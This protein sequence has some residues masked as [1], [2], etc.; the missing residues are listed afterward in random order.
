VLQHAERFQMA[1]VGVGFCPRIASC[2]GR[3]GDADAVRSVRHAAGS[4][5]ARWPP[6]DGEIERRIAA[7]PGEQ[8]EIWA[9]RVLSAETLAELL[10]D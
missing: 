2:D 9:E 4:R 6:I 10:A 8:I 5:R 7:A 3:A 1:R